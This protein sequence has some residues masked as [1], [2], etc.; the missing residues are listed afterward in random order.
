MEILYIL[1]VLLVVTRFFGEL[2]ERADEV[3]RLQEGLLHRV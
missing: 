3:W 2:A 1:L